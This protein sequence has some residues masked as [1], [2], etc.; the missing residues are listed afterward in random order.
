MEIGWQLRLMLLQR[1][2]KN[3]VGWYFFHLPFL[4]EDTGNSAEAKAACASWGCGPLCTSWKACFNSEAPKLSKI[5]KLKNRLFQ[6]ANW[7]QYLHLQ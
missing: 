6:K 1:E 5:T 7:R 4:K 2:G 3:T